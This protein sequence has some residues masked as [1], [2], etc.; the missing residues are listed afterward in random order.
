[1]E[2]AAASRVSKGYDM[3]EREREEVRKREN[4]TSGRGKRDTASS[5]GP[6]E[7]L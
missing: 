3:R 4:E 5:G 6:H 2:W 7:Q 1:M